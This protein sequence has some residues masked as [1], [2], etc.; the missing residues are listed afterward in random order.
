MLAAYTYE[1]AYTLAIPPH[2]CLWKQQHTLEMGV[3]WS[4][5]LTFYKQNF[6][7]TVHTYQHI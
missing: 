2:V 6:I 5:L 1:C 4:P 7:D 3:K